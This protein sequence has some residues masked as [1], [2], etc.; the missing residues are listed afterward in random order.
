MTASQRAL[1]MPEVLSVIFDWIFEDR[2]GGCIERPK[3]EEDADGND[4][5]V[6]RVYYEGPSVLFHCA[7]VNKLWFDESIRHLWREPYIWEHS[8][9]TTL[10]SHMKRLE[11]ARRQF[12]ANFIEAATDRTTWTA[13]R[14]DSVLQGIRFPKLH[15]LK[16]MLDAECVPKIE[17]HNIKVLELDPHFEWNPETYCITQDTMDTILDQIAVRPFSAFLSILVELP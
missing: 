15:H 2:E 5:G 9:V 13:D 7:L 4:D 11:P 17:G 8:G 16:L 12:Y 6:V 1:L 10:T 3:T 14:D